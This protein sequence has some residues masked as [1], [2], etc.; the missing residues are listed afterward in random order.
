MGDDDL[1][2]LN[3]LCVYMLE[4][5]QVIASTEGDSLLCAVDSFRPG[6]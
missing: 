3:I 4:M 2:T 5:V 1:A 6:I